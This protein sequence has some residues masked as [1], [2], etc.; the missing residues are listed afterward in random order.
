MKTRNILMICY[1]YPP[2]ID[3]GCK[4]SVAFSK[5]FKKY[6]WNPVV[7]SVKNPD[8][9]YCI[10]GND[11][12]PDGV[13]TQYSYSLINPYK[14]LG[15]MNGLLSKFLKMFGI[16][17]RRNYFY[18][19]FCI[20]DFFCGWIPL[21]VVK[22]TKLI[23]THHIDF[24]YVSCPPFSAAIIGIALKRL[25]QKP[26]ILDFRDPFRVQKASFLALPRIRQRTDRWLERWFLKRT[27]LLVVTSEELRRRYISVYPNVKEKAFT[28]HNGVDL[29]LIPRDLPT[30]KFA[31]FTIVYAGLYFYR[32]SEW[33]HEILFKALADLKAGNHIDKN[34]FQFLFFGES[35][36]QIVDIARHHRVLDLV[37]ANSRLTYQDILRIISRSHLQLLRGGTLFIPSKLYDGIV[38]NVPFLATMPDGEAAEIVRCY[39]PSS[40]TLHHE[41]SDEIAA[42]ILDAMEKYKRYQIIDN[43]V[44]GFVERFSR[45]R[46]TVKLMEI[47]KKDIQGRGE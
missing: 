41:S 46:L 23:K 24:I 26:L 3:V 25:T 32:V 14:I 28:V 21:T 2:L 47:I 10:L 15:K 35:K 4:R 17:L 9:I 27:N 38:L 8:K 33:D 19:I 44:T 34:K 13:M 7:L 11:K 5:Y 16:R 1:Y 12:P 36:E 18:D 39:S 42:A 29:D 6:G 43:N 45:E 20:P 31:K 37:A 30:I 22:A 40:Y